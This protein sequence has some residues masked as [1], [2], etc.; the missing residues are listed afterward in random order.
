MD[1]TSS[2][3]FCSVSGR[4]ISIE[5][6]CV[7]Q[8][9]LDTPL[10]SL[11][12]TNATRTD[13]GVAYKRA[14][15]SSELFCSVSGEVISIEKFSVFLKVLDTTLASL[16]CTHATRTDIGVAY[17]R[18]VTS[19]ELFWSVSGRIISIEKLSVFRKV[20]DTTLVSL[21][22]THATRTDIGVA[23]R[24]NVTSSELFRSVSGRIIS[25]EKFSVFLKVLDTTFASL[26]SSI[27]TRTDTGG[28]YR[29]NV[30][31]SE[32]FCSVSGEVIS[33]EKF[34]VFLKVLDTTL[35]SLHSSIATRTDT[36]GTY[37]RNVTSSEL[38]WSVSGRIISIEKLSV[39]LKVLDPTFVSLHCTIAT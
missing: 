15:T 5:K 21:H 31:S 12:C 37:R 32:L 34:S 1:V 33:I 9:V 7:L 6:L 11:H 19:S 13:S 39:F 8:K 3:L 30:T 36:G 2:E 16:H 20:L 26:H 38:F 10:A 4:I 17:R 14:V 23:Y 29:R 24:R 27:A 25:I 18:N 22:C 28:T 35:A